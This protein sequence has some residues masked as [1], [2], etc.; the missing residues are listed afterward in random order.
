MLLG[1]SL[2]VS[3]CLG[4][5]H[6]RV[7]AVVLGDAFGNDFGESSGGCLEGLWQKVEWQPQVLQRDTALCDRVSQHFFG[8]NIVVAENESG[9]CCPEYV[10]FKSHSRNYGDIAFG[11]KSACG[12]V[13]PLKFGSSSSKEAPPIVP[14]HRDQGPH[15]ECGAR[16]PTPTERNSFGNLSLLEKRTRG[17]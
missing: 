11:M 5:C 1:L 3:K 14:S 6:W 9:T 2:D 12:F 15:S 13:A 17:G 4:R 8:L 16:R 7:F 10:K